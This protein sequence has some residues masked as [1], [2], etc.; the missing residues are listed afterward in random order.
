M[1][2]Y[3]FY[4]EVEAENAQQAFEQAQNDARYWHGHSGYTGTVAEKMSFKL[5]GLPTHGVT[6]RDVVDAILLDEKLNRDNERLIELGYPRDMA[7]DIA[8]T[9][10]DKWGDALCLKTGIKSYAFA[11]IA[12][13]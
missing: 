2:A 10:F 7:W 3:D 1:G 9:Y 8:N 12:S 5:Y 13:A 4:C 11:G 6:A